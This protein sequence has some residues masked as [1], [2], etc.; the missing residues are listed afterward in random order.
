ML[1]KLCHD[2]SSARGDIASVS[3]KSDSPPMRS[4]VCNFFLGSLFLCPMEWC[5]QD[6]NQPLMRGG[7]ATVYRAIV[8]KPEVYAQ[9]A[10]M[11][12]KYETDTREGLP[13]AFLREMDAVGKLRHPHLI[14]ALGFCLTKPAMI[15]RVALCNLRQRADHGL[16][17]HQ[18]TRFVFQITSALA[19]LHEA[20]YMHRDV[21]PQKRAHLRRRD[22]DAVR[23]GVGVAIYPRPAQHPPLR[24]HL[25]SR[26]GNL[27]L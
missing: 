5:F 1:A 13:D 4:I 16:D 11:I 26:P 23:Y 21:K 20:N 18:V 17:T 2:A 10:V 19:Y 25:V 3:S 24:H 6:D 8:V 9:Q 22:G 15:M 14:E 7:Q 27:L 12:K